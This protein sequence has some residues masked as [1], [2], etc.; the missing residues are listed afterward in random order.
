MRLTTINWDKSIPLLTGL[1]LLFGALHGQ[2][3]SIEKVQQQYMNMITAE[4]LQGSL[5][6]ISSDNLEGRFTGSRGEKIAADYLASQYIEMGIS[7][8]TYK[9]GQDK[10]L[11]YFQKFEFLYN[12]QTIKS[13]NV[14]A[15]IEGTDAQLKKEAV[16]IMAHYDHKG[17]DTT[18]Q[19]DQILNGAADD[20]SGTVAIL[21][22]AESFQKAKIN[23]EGPLRS[24]IFL[25]NSAEEIGLWGSYYYVNNPIISLENTVAVINMDG[26][27]G[28]DP[29]NPSGS[30]NY[31]YMVVQDSTSKE[32][33]IKNEQLNKELGINLNLVRPPVSYS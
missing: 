25:H 13:Q 31:V 23:G 11:N 3:K 6:Y 17:I 28:Y 30:R 14:I 19:G 16:I 9:P 33:L 2:N 22:I 10:V 27:G 8:A 12:G 21:E 26:V 15:Y 1:L 20:G 7:P 24:V 4:E 32:L 29:K 18:L 5:Y